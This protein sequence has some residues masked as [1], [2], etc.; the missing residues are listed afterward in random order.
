MVSPI[1][2][3]SE[4]GERIAMGLVAFNAKL[5]FAN[6]VYADSGGKIFSDSEIDDLF[7]DLDKESRE[8]A[9]RFMHHQHKIPPQGFMIH[10]E[11]FY[12]EAEN[13]EYRKLL[14]D[15]TRSIRRFK[16][17]RHL[18]GPEALYYHHGLRFAPD[19][20]KKHISGKIFADVG[21]W[22]G[23]S[24]L[25]F[26][27]YSPEKIVVFEPDKNNRG[28]LE[29]TLK[30]NG[31]SGDSYDLHPWGLSDKCTVSGGFD[32]ALLMMSAR[33]IQLLSGF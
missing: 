12:S 5:Q 16:L 33:T 21:G 11:Y 8:V 32:V 10:P 22:L 25:V 28:K 19:F 9:K 26:A 15:F 30:R 17:K 29:K 18:V 14:K 23:D 24:A 1:L 3:N 13:A 7:A 2:R 4:F 27:G 6:F 20:V 31:I